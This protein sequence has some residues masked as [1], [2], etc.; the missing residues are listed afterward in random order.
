MTRKKKRDEHGLFLIEGEKMIHEAIRSNYTIKNI[1]KLE[2][3]DFRSDSIEPKHVDEK[4]MAL[5]SQ[6][7]SPS[8]VLAIVEQK[9]KLLDLELLAQSK[10]L[11]LDS[12]RDPGNLGTI[13]RSADWFGVQSIIASPDTVDLFNIKV[14]QAS[15]GA[16]FR[17]NV[18]YADLDLI[19]TLKEINSDFQVFGAFLNGKSTE[20]LSNSSSC[21][22]IMIGNES[23]GISTLGSQYVDVPVTIK[24]HGKSESLNAAISASILLYEWCASPR[25]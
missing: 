11:V 1:Y 8:P 3:S 17:T 12:I 2:S 16:I 22:A 10:V 24:G 20:V 6:Q 25:N 14:V 9:D 21:G 5:I 7:A 13:I 4:E 15:M 18:Y 23:I 19:K